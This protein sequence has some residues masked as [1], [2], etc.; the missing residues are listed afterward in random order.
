MC[1][2]ATSLNMDEATV[3]RFR[4]YVGLP[5]AAL[6]ALRHMMPPMSPVERWQRGYLFLATAFRS[7]LT[8][9]HSAIFINNSNSTAEC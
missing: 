2:K 3:T 8:L 4:S 5:H 9:F 7:R 6:M 1:T